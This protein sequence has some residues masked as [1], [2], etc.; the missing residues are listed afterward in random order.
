M[1]LHPSMVY[2]KGAVLYQKRISKLMLV[3]KRVFQ[4]A[5]ERGEWVGL[6][7]PAKSFI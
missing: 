4:K 5:F 1:F 6:M 7:N 2:Y 3:E